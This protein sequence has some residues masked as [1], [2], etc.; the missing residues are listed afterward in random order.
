MRP[1]PVN[2][3]KSL[4]AIFRKPIYVIEI[5]G[6]IPTLDKSALE[7]IKTLQYH[8]GFIELLNRLKIQRAYLETQL[9]RD[10]NADMRS[11]QQAIYW[12]EYFE[13]EVEAAVNKRTVPRQVEA[14][15]DVMAEFE[16]INAGI[17]GVSR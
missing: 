2:L 1:T 15:F 17:V 6:T 9:K 16:K 13:R 7:S 11:L 4:L 14:E 12:S 10:P 3:L 5:K 8:A